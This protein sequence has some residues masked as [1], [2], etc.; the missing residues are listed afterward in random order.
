MEF[1]VSTE[2]LVAGVGDETGIPSGVNPERVVTLFHT[3]GLTP[4]AFR[5]QRPSGE[6][7]T[8]NYPSRDGTC[9]LMRICHRRPPT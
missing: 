9:V 6:A 8:G 7:V 2:E 1:N 5:Y 4:A 3:Q